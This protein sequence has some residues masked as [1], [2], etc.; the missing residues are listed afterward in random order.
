MYPVHELDLFLWSKYVKRFVIV[1]VSRSLGK[2]LGISVA[3]VNDVDIKD[4]SKGN[5]QIRESIDI[6]DNVP[7][8]PVSR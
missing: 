8:E 4:T 5:Y 2:K 7:S 1:Q 6:D 3:D